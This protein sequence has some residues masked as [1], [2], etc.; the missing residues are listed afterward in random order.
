ML[1]TAQ[2]TFNRFRLGKQYVVYRA[3]NNYVLHKADV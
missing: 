3:L 1:T 2:T